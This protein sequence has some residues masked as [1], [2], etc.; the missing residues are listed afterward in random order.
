MYYIVFHYL[1]LNFCKE[2]LLS[3]FSRIVGA[4]PTVKYAIDKGA[5]SIVLMSHLGR[6]DGKVVEKFSLKPIA[7]E[8]KKLLGK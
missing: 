8:L 1:H 3:T 7:E 2:N 5:K 4:L 6:P